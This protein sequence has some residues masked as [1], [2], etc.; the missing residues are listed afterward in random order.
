MR[1]VPKCQNVEIKTI[2]VDNFPFVF[3]RTKVMLLLGPGVLQ[4][5]TGRKSQKIQYKTPLPYLL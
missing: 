2:A 4:L 1:K 5:A 3:L